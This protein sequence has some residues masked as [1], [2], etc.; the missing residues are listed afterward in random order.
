MEI[1]R[2][3]SSLGK[4]IEE[5]RASLDF[6]KREQEIAVLE[7]KMLEPGFWD[8]QDESQQVMQTISGIKER[9]ESIRALE[10]IY[11]DLT[12]L[13][14]LGEEEDDAQTAQELAGELRNLDR[15][16]EQSELRFLLN[17]QY[18][19]NNAII[20]L[21]AGAGGTEAQDWVQMLLR[22]YMRWAEEK[23]YTCE[24][25]DLLPG[26]EAGVKSATMIVSGRNAY[27]YLVSE[28]GVHRLVRISPFDASGR[29]HTSFASVD[30]LPEVEEETTVQINPGDLKVDTFRSSGAGGQHINKTDSAVRI[31]HLPTGIVVVC[32]G[33]RSQISNRNT[34]LK[35]LRAK[36]ADLELK[37]KEEEQAALRGEKTEIAWGSQIRSYVFQP[38][39]M[40]KDHRTGVEVGNVN[41]VMDGRIDE[42]IASYLKDKAKRNL[43]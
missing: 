8:N 12:V 4:R 13:L 30:V 24:M 31:T 21:H 20:S 27:G 43:S 6:V 19:A 38:Y 36:L 39:T 40:V 34:A 41:A 33:E 10:N 9:L 28:K 16:V 3:L 26:D 37:K 35:L 29:R 23:G 32:Q 5:L 11:E 15:L 25:A 22:M 2:E 14:A 7:Q 1:A 18:D 42:F 17:G